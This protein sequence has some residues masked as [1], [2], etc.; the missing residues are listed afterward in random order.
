MLEKDRSTKHMD[1]V[2]NGGNAVRN[3]IIIETI[4]VELYNDTARLVANTEWNF[5]EESINKTLYYEVDMEYAAFLTDE[6]SDPFVLALLELAMERQCDIE[7]LVP[8]SEDL[9]YQLEEYLIPVFSKN[10]LGM[11]KTNL[12]GP[13]SSDTI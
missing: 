7:Y 11:Y 13:T 9:K 4:S 1:P 8:M 5:G 2:Q 12:I 6:R 10:L 3:K